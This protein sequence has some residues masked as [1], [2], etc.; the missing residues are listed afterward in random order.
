MDFDFNSYTKNLIN[1]ED[2]TEYLKRE[3][4]IK[5]YFSKHSD[6]LYWYDINSYINYSNSSCYR[7]FLGDEYKSKQSIYLWF[8]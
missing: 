8:I 2:L 1:K 4:E 7:N 5:K 6:D 3:S